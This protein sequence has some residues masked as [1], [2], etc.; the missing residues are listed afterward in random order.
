MIVSHQHRF[1]FIKT[2][3]TAGTSIEM[4]LSSIC[5]ATDI[6]SAISPIDEKN[7]INHGSRSAQ[8]F[9]IPFSSYSIKDF[10]R[11][12]LKRKRKKYY[13]HMSAAEIKKALPTKIWDSY[14][15]FTIER[16]PFDKMVSLYFWRKG[17]EKYGNIYDFLTKGGFTRFKGSKIYLINNEIAVDKV[18][19]FEEL[20]YMLED[21][22]RRLTLEKSL[23]L[24]SYRA[25]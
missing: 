9:Y 1:I 2:Q 11:L 15:K 18:Y 4:A 5:G 14:F 6:I 16:N 21:F 13:S 8:N 22:N 10:V 25:N 23:I 12:I 20:P 19:Q 17:D 3:K 24:G 7:R